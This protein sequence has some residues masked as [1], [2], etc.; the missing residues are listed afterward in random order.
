MGVVPFPDYYCNSFAGHHYLNSKV[1]VH[2]T[3]LSFKS[4]GVSLH[5]TN[6]TKQNGT[7]RS[8]HGGNSTSMVKQTKQIS[9]TAHLYI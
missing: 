5:K 2:K 9:G 4:L 3:N 1:K 7:T 6:A 8:N